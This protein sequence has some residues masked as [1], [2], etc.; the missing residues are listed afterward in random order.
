MAMQG[1]LSCGGAIQHS[2]M[3]GSGWCNTDAEG[4]AE[5]AVE[6]AD[7]LLKQLDKGE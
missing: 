4:M 3:S 1:L 6:C 5:L 2:P 7:A